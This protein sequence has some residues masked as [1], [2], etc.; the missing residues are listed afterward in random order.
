MLAGLAIV[1]PMSLPPILKLLLSG[2][3]LGG[4]IRQCIRLLRGAARIQYYSFEALDSIAGI[5][6]DGRRRALILLEGSI[7]LPRFA[8]LRVRFP[9]GSDYVELLRGAAAGDRDWQCLQL[10]WRLRRTV[11]GAHDGS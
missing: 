4:N 11:V 8:W 1:L 2:A 7:L 6:P 3:W 5:G 9:D 10:I